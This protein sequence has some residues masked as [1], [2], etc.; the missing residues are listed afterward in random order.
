MK[1]LFRS[2]KKSTNQSRAE[3][4]N[5]RLPEELFRLRR[6]F[7]GR[8]AAG[9]FLDWRKIEA[10]QVASPALRYIAKPAARI[11]VIAA[12][13]QL[14]TMLLRKKMLAGTERQI[15][16]QQKPNWLEVIGLLPKV[17]DLMRA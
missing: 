7:V 13:R 14:V 3:P 2:D 16:A 6:G 5:P 12:G 8:L 4:D 10:K 9:Y 11:I 17:V 1:T 15:P